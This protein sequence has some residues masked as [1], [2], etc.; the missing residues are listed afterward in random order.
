MTGPDPQREPHS[1]TEEKKGILKSYEE[2]V[3]DDGPSMT[4]KE[5]KK[6]KERERQEEGE[7]GGQEST[8]PAKIRPETDSS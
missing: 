8:A 3:G 6:Q 2:F 1:E 4:K 5:Y 7:S